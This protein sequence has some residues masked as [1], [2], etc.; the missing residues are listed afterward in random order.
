MQPFRTSHIKV[1]LVD[2][3]HF[4][5]RTER[6]QHVEDFFGALP[7][8]LWMAVDKDGMWA[9]FCGSAQRH[10]RVDAKLARFI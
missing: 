9:M 2:R 1:S 10:G 8:A 3:R 4:H 5:L 6:A 7:V